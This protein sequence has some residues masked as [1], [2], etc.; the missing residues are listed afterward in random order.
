MT[1]PGLY[2]PLLDGA[3]YH[4]SEVS[5]LGPAV[6]RGQLV[7]A[8]RV[9]AIDYDAVASRNL[10]YIRENIAARKKRENG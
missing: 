8:V 10:G 6:I 1:T 2:N 3:Q 7:N 4:N 5:D 9:V